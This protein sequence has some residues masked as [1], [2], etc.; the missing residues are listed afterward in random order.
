MNEN[1]GGGSAEVWEDMLKGR[2]D[3]GGG[4]A[5]SNGQREKEGGIDVIIIS[6]SRSVS[7]G[8]LLFILKK[9]PPVVD[10]YCLS[11]SGGRAPK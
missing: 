10:I 3:V 2:Q 9:T 1:D 5:T 4:A 8:R 7:F 11:A 6:G